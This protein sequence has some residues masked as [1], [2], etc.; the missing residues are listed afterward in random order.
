[1]SYL[2][3]S[4]FPA[5]LLGG[6][7]HSGKSVLAQSLTKAL[8]QRGIQHYLLR[9]APDGEGSWFHEAGRSVAERLRRKG[10]FT[11]TWVER[12]CRDIAARPLPFLVDIGGRPEPW[13]EGIIDQ[14]THAILLTTNDDTLAEWQER[15]ARYNLLVIASLTSRPTGESQL[16]ETGGPV[17]QGIISQLERGQ[18]VSGPV[19]EAVLNRVS[20][21]FAYSYEELLSIHH[22]QAPVELVVDLP[23]MYRQLNPARPGYDWQ[24]ADLPQ[25]FD[26]LPQDTPLALYG[27]GPAWLYAAVAAYIY[28]QPFYQ[29]DVRCGWVK[30][31]TFRD[32]PTGLSSIKLDPAQTPHGL[33]LKIDL[34]QDY[35]VYEPELAL[36][37][38]PVPQA[39]GA[40]SAAGVILDGKLPNWLYTSLALFYHSAPWVAV[41]YPHQDRAV[42]VASQATAGPYAVGQTLPYPL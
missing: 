15:V 2:R 21:L 24:P 34:P 33:R 16:V 17:I 31:V 9:A 37:L 11:P 35:L 40:D 6:P 8:T 18:P 36:S 5:I 30:P 20:A 13:Q 14:C 39:G 42:V 12:I 19:F 22:E 28:P 25:V 10:K 7:P 4:R 29:F 23:A 3:A 1:M 27:R 41:Y 32:N 26:Y 38:P